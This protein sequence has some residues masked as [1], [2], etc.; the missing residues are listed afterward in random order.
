MAT[1]LCLEV[2]NV[3]LV[4][5]VPGNSSPSGD[6]TSAEEY[7]EGINEINTKDYWIA[8]SWR[9]FTPYQL[10]LSSHLAMFIF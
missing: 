7:G 3:K 9:I 1:M 4:L 10:M 8:T 6:G 2:H 5:K